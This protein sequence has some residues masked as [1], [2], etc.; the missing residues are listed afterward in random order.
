LNRFAWTF[1]RFIKDIRCFIAHLPKISPRL[2]FC[3][4]R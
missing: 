4:K 1:G 2:C 3:Q